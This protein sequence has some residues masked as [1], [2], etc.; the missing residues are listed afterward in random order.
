M[1][2]FLKCPNFQDGPIVEVAQFKKWLN[3]KKYPISKWLNLKNGPI[4]KLLNLKNGS[5]VK[6]AQL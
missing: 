3:S 1:A 6:M 4:F 5:I 2:Q